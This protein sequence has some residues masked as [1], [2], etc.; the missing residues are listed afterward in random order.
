MVFYEIRITSQPRIRFACSDTLELRPGSRNI[1]DHRRD[2][3]ELSLNEYATNQIATESGS[4]TQ[5]P[6]TLGVFMPDCRYVITPQIDEPTRVTSNSVAVQIDGLDYR[7]RDLPETEAAEIIRAGDADTIFLPRF[8]PMDE[9][10][11]IMYQSISKTLMNHYAAAGASER[12]LA[13]ACWY[14][15]AALVNTLFCESVLGAAGKRDASGAYYVH[16]AKKYLC[17]HFCEGLT[18]EQVAAELGISKSYLCGV[19]RAGT[20]QTVIGYI[21]TLRMQRVRERITGTNDSFASI[22][23]GVG[24]HDMRYAQRLFKKHFGVSMQRCR[25]LEHGIS[26]YHTNPWKRDAIDHDIYDD[27]KNADGQ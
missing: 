8:L 16:K 4:Y 14:E 13:V 15:L 5:I 21:N 23:A 3:I 12:M 18:L 9:D 7:R 11:L 24:L 26:L 25:Q 1:I 2:M 20:G 19:F 10:T 27:E 6:H 22:C 17:A